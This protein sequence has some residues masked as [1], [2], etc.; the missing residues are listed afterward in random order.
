[1]T[2]RQDESIAIFQF[3]IFRVVFKFVKIQNSEHI[4]HSKRSALVS[5]LCRRDHGD[6][7]LSEAICHELQLLD[8]FLV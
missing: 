3:R 7:V 4:R 8:F 5:A 1:M 6:H 2:V